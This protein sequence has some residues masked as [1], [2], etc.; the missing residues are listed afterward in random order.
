MM[1][2]AETHG[3]GQRLKEKME[4]SGR[5]KTWKIKPVQGRERR[6]RPEIVKRGT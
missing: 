5:R 3:T 1:Q 2:G 6:A 4:D